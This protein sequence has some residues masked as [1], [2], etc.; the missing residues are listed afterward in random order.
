MRVPVVEEL[1]ERFA[2]FAFG[3]EL[4]ERHDGGAASTAVDAVL[5]SRENVGDRA[6]VAQRSQAVEGPHANDI[7]PRRAIQDLDQR[8]ERNGLPSLA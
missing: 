6:I 5:G 3:G 1:L 8:I 2:V 4:G 7:G